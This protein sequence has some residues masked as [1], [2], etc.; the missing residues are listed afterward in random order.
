MKKNWVVFL[1]IILIIEAGCRKAP[2]P[3]DTTTATT[4][5]MKITIQNMAGS[6]ELVLNNQWY[7][8]E[9]GDSIKFKT[10][11]YFISNIKLVRTDGVVFVQPES[12]FLIK[13]NVPSSKSFI[14]TN[15]PIGTYTSISFLIGVDSARNVSGA[16]TG[17]LDQGSGMFWDWNTGYVMAKIEGISPQS[18]EVNNNVIYHLGGFSGKNNVLRTIHLNT[19][20]IKTTTTQVVNLHIKADALEWFKTPNLIKIQDLAIIALDEHSKKIADNYAD[21]FSIDHI[22]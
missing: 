5:S 16:Q 13:E 3:I 19:P 12:Y 6:A 10:F 20:D 8:N 9:N 7:K 4:G 18:T 11:N 22:D 17:A 14:I 15:I 1:V 2:D 21:M